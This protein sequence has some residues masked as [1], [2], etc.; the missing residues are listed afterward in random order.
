MM[1]TEAAARLG[2]GEGGG[3]GGGGAGG[4]GD[5]GGG[6]SGFTQSTL[7]VLAASPVVLVA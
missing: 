4:G 7:K 6:L 3:G 1:Y 2:A 5:G